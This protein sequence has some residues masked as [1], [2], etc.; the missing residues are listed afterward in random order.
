MEE[1]Y[2]F[3]QEHINFVKKTFN[4]SL[5]FRLMLFKILPMGFLSGMKITELNEELCTVNVPYKRL[6]KNPF[7]STFWAVLGMA[8]EMSSGGLMTLYTHKQKPSI[9][10]LVADCKGEFIKKATDVTSFTC[11]DGALIKAKIIEAI[12]TKEGQ[13]IPTTMV[14]KNE[15]GEVVAKFL[16]TWTI[17]ARTPKNVK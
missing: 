16:F 14:G 17:K 4:N 6:N 1:A 13:I 3:N 11:S 2:T 12:K 15:A 9:S 5:K 7:N 8:A 10:M